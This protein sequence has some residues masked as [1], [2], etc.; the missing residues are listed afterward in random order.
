MPTSS[1]FFVGQ[2][3]V[4][5]FLRYGGNTDQLRMRV[6][7]LFQMDIPQPLMITRL[8]ALYHGVVICMLLAQQS[9]PWHF[10]TIK[11]T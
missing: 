9:H 1:A 5:Q 3:A 8:Q 7:H 10:I 6:I 2:Q 4:D 11:T